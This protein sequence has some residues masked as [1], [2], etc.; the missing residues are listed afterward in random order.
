REIARINAAGIA[1]NARWAVLY[2]I[3]WHYPGFNGIFAGEREV[4]IKF[5]AAASGRLRFAAVNTN[6]PGTQPADIA[7]Q[8]QV[9]GGF[10][11]A[12]IV[13]NAALPCFEFV[14]CDNTAVDSAT[15]A[16]DDTVPQA[17]CFTHH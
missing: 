7:T 13:G 4:I 6:T 12:G 5:A 10:D 9:G 3:V 8:V 14:F 1:D 11:A 17:Q 15:A 16:G 2:H